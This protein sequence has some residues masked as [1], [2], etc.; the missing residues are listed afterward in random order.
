[1]FKSCAKIQ[2][3]APLTI[4]PL[5]D[6]IVNAES[7]VLSFTAENSL[8][9]S[10]VPGL[11]DL[12]K[13][14]ARD[15]KALDSLSMNRTTASYKT[16][17]GVG[18][19]FHDIVIDE[20]R[21]NHFSLNMD[22]S[23]SSNFQKVLTILVSY[24]CAAKNEVVIHH[25][26]SLT[27]IKVNS[28]SLFTK[29]VTLM[30][31]NEIPWTNL[32]S[33]LMDSCNVMRGSKSGLE[34][35]IRTEK[36]PHLLDVDGDVCHHVHN[37]AKAFCKPFK[38]FI[39]QLYNDLFNDFKWSPDLREMFQEICIMLNI[40]YAMPQRYVS[41]RW[42]S[43]YDVTLDTLRLFDALTVF[44]FPLLTESERVKFLPTIVEVYHRLGVSQSSRE[45][46]SQIRKVMHKFYFQFCSAFYHFLTNCF[47][48]EF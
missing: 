11:I 46:I 26:K 10:L 17:F 27:C 19:T 12:S 21:S 15:K 2:D 44:Y 40:K 22:E 3:P 29:L 23:T 48:I 16:R 35:R 6:R 8:S 24:F 7:M 1:M 28:E 42:L 43:V 9:F 25:F 41:H 13:A 5:N 47:Q 34:T 36:A 37:A 4:T 18:K 30:E 45:R 33:V 32:M 39:E 38:S 20:M 31:D 14:L